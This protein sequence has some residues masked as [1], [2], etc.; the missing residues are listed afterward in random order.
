MTVSSVPRKKID[1]GMS[2]LV[3]RNDELPHH[4]SA[5]YPK[6]QAELKKEGSDWKYRHIEIFKHMSMFKNNDG[7]KKNSFFLYS[8][9][10]YD[11]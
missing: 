10:C 8:S 1:I 7:S 6:R 3:K 2:K 9:L 5:N 4:V 11:F